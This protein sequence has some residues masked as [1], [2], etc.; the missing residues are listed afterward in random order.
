[1]VC[2]K[3]L[4]KAHVR[5]ALRYPLRC[6]PFLRSR[7]LLCASFKKPCLAFHTCATRPAVTPVPSFSVVQNTGVTCCKLVSRRDHEAEL[8]AASEALA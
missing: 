3:N 2:H 4:K 8:G 7:R 6:T 1:M 5:E